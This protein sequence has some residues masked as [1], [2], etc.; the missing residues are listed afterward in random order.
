MRF[1]PLDL[2]PSLEAAI[3]AQIEHGSWSQQ[4]D[5]LGVALGL[6]G[7]RVGEVRRARR[8]HLYVAGGQ[9]HVPSFKRGH[10]REITLHHSLVSALLTWRG[11]ANHPWLLFTRP[12]SQV[13]RTQFERSAGRLILQVVGER[14][15]FHSLRHTFAMRLYAEKPDVFLVQRMLGHHSIKSTEVYA[16]SLATVPDACL[17]RLRSDACPAAPVQLKLFSPAG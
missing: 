6:H 3:T 5:A 10:A 17:V 14:L 4:R 8:E 15:K 12:G 7:L 16:A 9:L 13:H 1:V 2:V 11:E